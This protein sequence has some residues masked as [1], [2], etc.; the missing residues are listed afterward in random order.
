MALR[1]VAKVMVAD[2][3]KLAEDPSNC[4]SLNEVRAVNE[5]KPTLLAVAVD[6]NQKIVGNT[7]IFKNETYDLD[8]E[9]QELLGKEGVVVIDR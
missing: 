3:E 7:D 5:G 4:L 9:V 2:L 6:R 8:K 1:N